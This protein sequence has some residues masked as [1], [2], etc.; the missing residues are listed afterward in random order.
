MLATA[1]AI[2]VASHVVSYGWLATI[3]IV[4]ATAGFV[5]LIVGGLWLLEDRT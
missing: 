1:V 4:L 3:V 5:A 2:L